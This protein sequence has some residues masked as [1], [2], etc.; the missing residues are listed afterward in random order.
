[1]DIILI[2][3]TRGQ[4][5]RMRLPQRPAWAIA[6]AVVV[7]AGML[8][9]TFWF[10]YTSAPSQNGVQEVMAAT[11]HWDDQINDQ[12]DEIVRLRQRMEDNV[13]ALAQRLGKLQAHVTRL[14]AVGE[15]MTKIAE[16]DT[17]EF[18][19][20]ADPP[21]GGPEPQEIA[22]TPSLDEF[23][24]AL[25][26][27]E[28]ELD[29]RERQMRVLR[30][31]MVARRLREEVVP[32]G[33][34]VEKGWISSTY[35]WRNDP[36]SGRKALHKG[37]DFAA[38]YGTGVQAVAAG[39]VT[40]AG[41]RSGYGKLVEINHGN[42]YATRYGHNRKVLV[43]EGQRVKKG[44]KIATIGSTGR[45]TGPHVHFEVLRN[46]RVVNPTEYIHASR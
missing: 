15:R 4:T 40:Y 21:V 31:L 39:V 12:R 28:R 16:L 9:G 19:F 20:D 46:G 44:D 38:G 3:R 37:I 18:N 35:G 22:S 26:Q 1:M 32:S 5:W 10:G 29:A 36:F 45:S 42:G 11:E 27:F 43:E 2:S 17:G 13:H 24:E 23:D 34:P 25:A 6:P 41:A 8:G 33:R 14:N 7:L 30:D